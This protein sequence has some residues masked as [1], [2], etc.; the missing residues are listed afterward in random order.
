MCLPPAYGGE[1]KKEKFEAVIKNQGEVYK[2][3]ALA[4]KEIKEVKVFTDIQ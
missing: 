2:L 3:P 4:W 1:E